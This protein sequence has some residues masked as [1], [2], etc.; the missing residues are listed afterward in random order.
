M[1]LPVIKKA[2]V[3]HKIDF[4]E[5]EALPVLDKL[6]ESVNILINSEMLILQLS[7]GFFTSKMGM[8]SC[9]LSCLLLLQEAN[10][11]S[12][13]FAYVDADKVNYWNYH[14]R[15]MRLLRPGGVVCYDN[16]LWSGTVVMPK[17]LVPEWL[18]VGKQFTIEFNEKISAD[19]R[20]Q[21]CQA[22]LGDGI[23]I[24]RRIK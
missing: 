22:P 11:G 3:E 17:E 18:E 4:M 7:Q 15:L 8:D 19:S 5:S 10:E 23:T 20:V 14:E 13:D 21:I 16:T 9:V 6:L 12:F 2:G 24:C 1:G